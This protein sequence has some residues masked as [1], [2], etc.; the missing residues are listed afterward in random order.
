MNE[1]DE[2]ASY[3]SIGLTIGSSALVGGI[4]GSMARELVP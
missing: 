2:S 3:P 1:S 4:L